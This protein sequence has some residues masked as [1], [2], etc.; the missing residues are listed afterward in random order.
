MTAPLLRTKTYL[1]DV[2]PKMV[3]RLRLIERLNA[4]LGRKLTLI[5]APAG[6]GKTTLASAWV[7]QI[8]RPVAWLS[9]DRSDN[10]PVQFWRYVAAAL[11]AAD[12]SIGETALVALQSPQSPPLEPLVTALINDVA[13]S[14]A[15]FILVLDD[16]HVVE[17]EEIHDSL[18]FLLDYLPRQLHVVIT[19]RADLPLSLARRRGRAELNEIRAV[20]LRFTVE[21]ATEFLNAHMGLDLSNEDAAALEDRTEGWIVGLQMAALSM[22]GMDDKH[23]FVATFTGDDRYVVDYLVEEVLQLQPPHVQAFLLQTSILER[24]CGPLCDAIGDWRSNQA[25]LSSQTTLEYLESANLFTIPLDNQRHWYRYHHL[26]ADLLRHRLNRSLGAQEIASLYQRASE[27]F[28][29]EGLIS[30]AVS[31]ALASGD[32]G[33]AAELI[34]QRVLTLFY[35]SETVLVHNWLKALPEDIIHA[36]PL[37]CAVYAACTMLASRDWAQSP[38]LSTL[39]EQWLQA[40]DDALASQPETQSSDKSLDSIVSGFIAK[41][42]AYLAQF[43]GDAPQKIIDL[44]RQALENL[45]KDDLM[46]RSALAYNLGVAYWRLGDRDAAGRA[47]GQA[48]QIGKASHDLFNASGGIC[49]QAELARTDG[50]LREAAEICR[51]GLQSISDLAGGRQVPYAGTIYITL[52]SILSERCEFEKAADTL[53]KGL[54]MIEL[55]SAPQSQQQGYIEMAHVQQARGETAQALDSLKRAEQVW[56]GAKEFIDSLRARIWLRQAG[57]DPHCLDDAIQWAQGLDIQ[58][59]GGG[60]EYDAVRLT[61]ARVILAQYRMQSTS[62]QPDLRPLLR[63]LDRQLE[64]AQEKDRL[65]WEIEVLIL[66]A[67]ALQTRGDVDQACTILERALTLAEPEGYARIFVDEGQPAMRLLRRAASRGIA[68]GYVSKLLAA[69]ERSGL[70]VSSKAGATSPEPETLTESLTP[71]E[72]EVLQLIVSGASNPEIAQTLFITVNTVK[73]HITNILGKLE[74]SNRTQAAVRARELG[75]VE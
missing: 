35:R 72:R 40:A 69:F 6:F 25:S 73:R 32:H 11:Q 64:L 52:G 21:E 34:E 3:V 47:F 70:Q 61:L 28:E 75:L 17:N 45:P 63:F 41:F 74:V 48:E 12:G 53:T 24:L 13:T 50:R 2:R 33:Y 71:R 67:L 4:G 62:G 60:D 7:R 14:S 9:L 68:Q 37:L 59:D 16:Y 36:H 39:V 56:P 54:A 23:R 44:S 5:S 26:F 8:E 43:R 1:P 27:W 42:R 20:D 19:T 58:L 30:E 29:A 15:P 55:T 46:F 65:G 31:Y 51:K 22:Q 66:Q 38:E 57:S 49:G 10:D 18:N